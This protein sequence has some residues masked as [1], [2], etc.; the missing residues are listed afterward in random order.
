MPEVRRR[1][2]GQGGTEATNRSILDAPDDG[3]QLPWFSLRCHGDHCRLAN[4]PITDWNIWNPSISDWRIQYHGQFVASRGSR[5]ILIRD[6]FADVAS[7]GL[8]T[9]CGKFV[10]TANA[11]SRT[12]ETVL[13][14]RMRT[15]C[16]RAC[17]R[18]LSVDM[19]CSR[20]RMV[21]VCI[22]MWDCSWSR[23]CRD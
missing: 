1:R 8:R 19:D 17:R 18:G 21:C 12:V 13:R 16:D 23:I 15:V 14:S 22:V 10:S 6:E 7:S 5:T 2:A 9:V 3:I 20:T 4:S 11:R